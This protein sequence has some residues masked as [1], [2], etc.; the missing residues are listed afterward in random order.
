[1]GLIRARVEWCEAEGVEI[2]CCPEAVLGGLADWAPRPAD[3]AIDV[4]SGRLAAVLEPL[5]SD[6]VTTIVGFTEISGDRLYNSA[7]VF[8]RGAVAGVY[9][10]LHPAIRRSVYHAG[11]ESPVFSVGGLTFGIVI[12]YDSTFPGPAR[13]MAARGATALFIPSNNG[14]PPEKADVVADSRTADIARATENGLWVIR[15]DTAGREGG[16]VS[17]GSSGIVAPDGTVARSARRLAEDLVV[18]E[19]DGDETRTIEPR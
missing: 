16:R 9:R 5:A 2:L 14:L 18:A 11:D 7:A 13:T 1:M 4:E 15:A 10:K 3:V 12:C 17:Y 6:A 19:I 8:H